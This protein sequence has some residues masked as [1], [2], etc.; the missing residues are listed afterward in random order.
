MDKLELLVMVVIIVILATLVW[1][2]FKIIGIW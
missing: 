2:V 1:G